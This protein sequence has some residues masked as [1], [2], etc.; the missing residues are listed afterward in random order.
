MQESL[1]GALERARN[2]ASAKQIATILA[3]VSGY[4]PAQLDRIRTA[5]I[6]NPQVRESWGVAEIIKSLS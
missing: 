2:F 4:T 5:S 1:I 6:E 3:T